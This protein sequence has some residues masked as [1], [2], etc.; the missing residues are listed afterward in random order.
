MSGSQAYLNYAVCF[1][2]GFS[3]NYVSLNYSGS[4]A[5]HDGLNGAGNLL[6]T[7]NLTPNAGSSPGYSAGFCPFSP[8]GVAFSGI[9]KS[10]AFGGVA[11]QIAFDD[12]TFG[13]STPGPG[14]DDGVAAPVPLPLVGVAA[15]FGYSRQLRKRIKVSDS[16]QVFASF[17]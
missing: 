6:A 4:V 1:G 9:A 16:Q 14:P 8:A 7:L 15:A 12:V 13:S 17:D 11:N 10:I 3:F 5:V 2:T